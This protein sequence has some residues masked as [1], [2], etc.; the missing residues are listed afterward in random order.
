MREIGKREDNPNASSL[1]PVNEREV[2]DRGGGRPTKLPR[3]G[4]SQCI[5]CEYDQGLGERLIVCESL[6]D[7][8][9][10]YDNYFRGGA[11]SIRWYRGVVLELEYATPAGSPS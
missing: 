7:M 8:Q 10:L 4:A 9:E 5:I 1:Q 11:I 2:N 6:G 3:L